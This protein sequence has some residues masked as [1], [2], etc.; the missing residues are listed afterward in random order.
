MVVDIKKIRHDMA[1]RERQ[2]EVQRKQ[3]DIQQKSDTRKFI[4]AAFAAFAVAMS[5]GA[6]IVILAA[7]LAGRLC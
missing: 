1:E 4:V 7:H 3:F 6:A 2:F 5:A